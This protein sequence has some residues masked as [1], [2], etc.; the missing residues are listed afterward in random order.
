MKEN[1]HMWQDSIRGWRGYCWGTP[2]ISGCGRKSEIPPLFEV[3]AQV[4]EKVAS[5][6]TS[7]LQILA[8]NV[9]LKIVSWLTDQEW[10]SLSSLS[11]LGGSADCWFLG[12]AGGKSCRGMKELPRQ[13]WDCP[14]EC[15]RR[16]R[17]GR[18]LEGKRRESRGLV[19]V[20]LRTKPKARACSGNP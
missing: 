1:P 11:F 10:S 4:W 14:E 3:G 9:E 12:K 13:K 7:S 20:P 6:F 16:P 19:R 17:S 18:G 15:G 2:N 8:G 5:S